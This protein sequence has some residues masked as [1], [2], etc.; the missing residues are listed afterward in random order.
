M[1]SSS[2]SETTLVNSLPAG[3]A[4]ECRPLST[5]PLGDEQRPRPRPLPGPARRPGS[6]YAASPFSARRISPR[7]C[8]I[9]P[10]LLGELEAV[11]GL[12]RLLDQLAQPVLVGVPDVEQRL[13]DL[14]LEL[15]VEV[16]L[17]E[18]VLLRGARAA[19]EDPL[20]D[21]LLREEQ[22][23][24]HLAALARRT[25]GRRARSSARTGAPT[26]LRGRACSGP[27]RLAVAQR[28]DPLAP[29]ESQSSPRRGPS[30][31]S[32]HISGS[33][34]IERSGSRK[35]DESHR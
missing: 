33:W 14:L 15:V 28:L 22:L 4:L 27:E 24:R 35:N 10:L 29:E 5:Q 26:G 11:Q 32:P 3:A 17:L 34:T 20:E 31:S 13:D 2:S 18:E 23:V 8:W 7:S 16:V 9:D 1:V 19:E 25:R 12:G 21:V 30:R 6:P